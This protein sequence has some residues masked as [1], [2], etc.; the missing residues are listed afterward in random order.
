MKRTLLLLFVILTSVTAKAVPTK[1]VTICFDSWP[2]AMIPPNGAEQ[3]QH[4][5]LVD[6]FAEIY[7]AHGYKITYKRMPYL[8]SVKEVENGNCDMG[9]SATH[10]VSAKALF[11][12]DPSYIS[13]YTFFARRDSSFKY[14][15]V[16]SLE[17]VILGNVTGYD[18]S[19]IDPKFQEYISRKNNKMVFT[20]AGDSAV[21]RIF[22]L[23]A[24]GRADTFCE[25]Y[26]VGSYIIS[27][28]GLASKFKYAGEIP[29]KLQLYAIYN[30]KDPEKSKELIKLYENEIQ[31]NKDLLKKYISRYKIEWIVSTRP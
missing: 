1:K 15:G 25:D 17:K 14:S 5:F 26:N 4:G 20:V 11:S 19:S 12:K 31:K 24:T 23:I 2:P 21:E 7:S 28:L 9:P 6:M 30:P 29:S 13:T 16:E 8:R 3:S 22:R 27:S 10:E 18:Y